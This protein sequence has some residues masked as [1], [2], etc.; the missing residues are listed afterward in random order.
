MLLVLVAT[1]TACGS[2]EI[3]SPLDPLDA[4]SDAI[5]DDSTAD[6]AIDEGTT[7]SGTEDST[8]GDT[9]RGDTRTDGDASTTDTRVTDSAADGASCP[10]G[11]GI[12]YD[13]PGCGAASA[14]KCISH[15]QDPCVS[16]FCG[17]DG[18]TYTGG[19]NI[20]VKPFASLGP[21][22]S[23]DAAADSTADTNVDDTTVA[24]D[25]EP[26]ADSATSDTASTDTAFDSGDARVCTT[27][28]DCTPGLS[29]VQGQCIAGFAPVYCC[30][31]PTCPGNS[32]CQSSTG[33]FSQ[34]SAPDGGGGFD[35]NF[36]A[37]GRCGQIKCNNANACMNA[38]CSACG[39]NKRCMP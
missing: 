32:I 5:V 10:V 16:Q 22:A 8:V 36:D 28:C 30:G 12:Y 21:C 1:T 25:T 2:G 4:E 13:T 18:V 31:A 33:S 23:S 39:V 6:V 29:C 35:A 37:A 3:E 14:P 17:C 24:M 7:D 26:V 9:N 15:A 19:C 11:E 20:S 38:G 34:C 27:A